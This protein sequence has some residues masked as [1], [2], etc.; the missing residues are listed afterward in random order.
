M[1]AVIVN[2]IISGDAKAYGPFLSSQAAEQ[3]GK[4][5]SWKK[6]E[7]YTVANLLPPKTRVYERTMTEL[8]GEWG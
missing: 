4:N 2:D 1:Y 5:T 6:D 3:W 7:V 8:W